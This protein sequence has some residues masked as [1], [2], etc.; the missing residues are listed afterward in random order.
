MLSSL[1]GMAI[2]L[3]NPISRRTSLIVIL[4]GIVVPVTLLLI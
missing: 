1:L 2:A 4:A 3:T